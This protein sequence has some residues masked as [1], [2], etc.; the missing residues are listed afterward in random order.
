MVL[1]KEGKLIWVKIGN[2]ERGQ[3]ISHLYFGYCR[4]GLT[5]VISWIWDRMFNYNIYAS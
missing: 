1:R 3:L 2:S 4:K 5:V